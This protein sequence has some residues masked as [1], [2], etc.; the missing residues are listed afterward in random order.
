MS[1]ETP[2]DKPK[3]SVEDH[4]FISETKLRSLVVWSAVAGISLLATCTFGFVGYEAIWGKSE[5]ENW[6]VALVREHSAAVIGTP[7]AVAAAFFIVTLLKVTRGAIEF[8]SFGVKFHGASGPIVFWILC[9][10]AVATALYFL[11]GKLA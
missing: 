10:A 7:A 9:F 2:P 3:S 5:P 8:E 1:E 6:L 11:W 4:L